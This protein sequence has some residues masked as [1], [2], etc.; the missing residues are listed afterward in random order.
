MIDLDEN[1]KVY[2][3]LDNHWIE[4]PIEFARECFDEGGWNWVYDIEK[5]VICLFEM[6]Y[7]VPAVRFIVREFYGMKKISWD[8]VQKWQDII[9]DNMIMFGTRIHDPKHYVH[10][11]PKEIKRSDYGI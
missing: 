2:Y 6:G 11:L 8:D 1:T 10:H 3:C 4:E 5:N 9:R 7:H